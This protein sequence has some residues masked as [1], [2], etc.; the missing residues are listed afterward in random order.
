M[1]SYTD[2]DR[3]GTDYE[4]L[5][6]R[7]RRCFKLVSEAEAD[8]RKREIEDLKFQ[9]P[10]LQWD[11]AAKRDR[12]GNGVTPPRPTLSI[13]KIDQP[14]QLV[15]N[16]MRAA[17]LGVEIHPVSE[18]ADDD[19]AE[20]LQGLYRSIERTSR[21]ELARSWA[22]D[23]AR[24][25]G[26]GVYRVITEYDPEGGHPTDQK[27]TI[28]RILYQAGVYFDPSAQEP[29]F[30]DGKWAF[31][32]TWM[33]RDD[34][35]REFPNAQMDGTDQYTWESL[36]I[37]APEWV[38]EEDMLVAEYWYKEITEEPIEG[39]DETIEKVAV[40]CAKLNGGEV[41]KVQGWNGKYIP[42]IPV[43]G[44]E[45][46]PFDE[47]RRWEGMIRPARDGQQL[48]N[49]SAS[50]LLER[51]AL[52]PKTPFIGAKGQFEGYRE[53]WKQANTRNLPYLEY[54]PIGADG[55]A[56]PPPQRAQ[57]DQSGMSLAM[58]A[59]QEADR[60]IQATT[61]VYD[62]SLGRETSRD[63][64]GKAILAL[65]GQADA[66]TSHYMQNFEDI[67]LTYE[68]KVILDLIPHVY[69]RPGRVAR[70]VRGDDDKS[71][72]VI[73]NAPFYRHPQTRRPI[74]VQPTS[75]TSVP[76]AGGPPAP[77]QGAK[78]M[79][80]DLRKGAGYG[81]AVSVGHSFQ[82]RLQEGSA[83]MGELLSAEP[84]LFMLMGDL[85]LRYQDWPGAKEMAD[86]MAKVREK[87]M[88]GL[89]E[90]D[91]GQP[92]PEQ[93]AAQAQALQQQLQMAQQQIAA[94]GKA[95]ETDAAKQQ[96]QI[97]MARMDL[98]RTR[99]DNESRERIAAANNETKLAIEGLNA[100]IVRINLALEHAFDTRARHDDMAHDVAMAAAGGRTIEMSR[101]GGQE[102]GQ[103]QGQESEQGSYPQP[104]PMGGEQA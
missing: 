57:I 80:Y 71:E 77:P 5:L 88:P 24:A 21:A 52:E 99:L 97:E 64:S 83:K 16:Q 102:Q 47:E 8:Q 13:S 59:L 46:Q 27:I 95:L 98:E 78:V 72:G 81:V 43:I 89:G 37:E 30:S 93:L 26:R 1:S 10:E 3:A 19:T 12:M 84:S 4:T 40:F 38:D 45:L 90:G 34:F 33:N 85:F 20:M 41:L 104:D 103:E 56:L 65:Q 48:Y 44:R 92:P 79:H 22:F 70:I 94:M 49:Y 87:Q 58:M 86:R 69:D 28:K 29:D 6:A 91:N 14:M 101:E 17:D 51:M 50:T 42:L 60:F 53:Q 9:I 66:G 63:K 67:S 23:R 31:V 76:R 55:K 2:E 74:M 75:A 7:A 61:S 82:T 100:Q 32:C 62:P 54:N 35:K 39:T 73:L 11:E 18:D 36:C 25:C 96:A 15:S 68:A